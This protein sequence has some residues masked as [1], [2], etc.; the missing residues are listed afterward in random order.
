MWCV[1]VEFVEELLES[2]SGGL[3]AFDFSVPAAMFGVCDEFLFFVEA[4]A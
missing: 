2:A 1:G 3:V 4:G